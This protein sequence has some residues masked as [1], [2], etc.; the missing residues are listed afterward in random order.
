M[1][2]SLEKWLIKEYITINII[3]VRGVRT[4]Q[5]K[6]LCAVVDTAVDTAVQDI[7]V[8][9]VPVCVCFNFVSKLRL[10]WEQLM[11]SEFN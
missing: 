3:L 2:S 5:H 8:K 1:G 6:N 10:E 4:S 7:A 11:N 9:I